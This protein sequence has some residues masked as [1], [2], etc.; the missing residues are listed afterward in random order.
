MSHHTTGSV[1]ANP[2]HRAL[3]TAILAG[4]LLV[5]PGCKIP[6]LCRATMGAALPDLYM[7]ADNKVDPNI[8]FISLDNSAQLGYREFFND[9]TLTGLMDQA[10]TGNQEL[11]ILAQEIRIANLDVFRRSGAYLPFVTLGG[12]TG[13]EKPSRFS[14][15]GAVDD[16]LLAA[17][18]KGFPDPLPRFLVAG[19]VS[20]EIDIWRRLRNS[21]DAASLRYLGTAEGRNYIVTRMVADVAE[22]YYELLAADN[23]LVTLDTTISLQEKSL[24]AATLLKDAGEGTE[25]AVQ[26]FQAE[27]RKN[28]SQKLIIQQEIVEAENQINFIAGRFPQTVDRATV[29]YI[30]LNLHAL[31]AGVPSQQLQN[32]ADIRQAER[33]LAAAG[34]DVRVARLPW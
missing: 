25:L 28:Q 23:R 3:R 20:W 26:R 31:S 15:L 14:P 32:R 16:Q 2:G 34:L 17:P 11:K 4:F 29:E 6:A 8:E 9:Q 30:D 7:G 24:A 5:L 18:G 21:R 1:N 27:V 22:N 19:D 33:E 10:L 13:L 12:L